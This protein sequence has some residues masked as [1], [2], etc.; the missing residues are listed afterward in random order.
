MP[1]KI[2]FYDTIFA[3]PQGEADLELWRLSEV[4]GNFCSFIK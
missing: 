4:S 1:S 2:Y 3:I